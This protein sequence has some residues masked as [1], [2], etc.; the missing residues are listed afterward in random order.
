[1]D[2]NAGAEWMEVNIHARRVQGSHS[3]AQIV[4]KV[5]NGGRG[6]IGGDSPVSCIWEGG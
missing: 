4:V 2:A 5:R 1:M 3:K 6:S